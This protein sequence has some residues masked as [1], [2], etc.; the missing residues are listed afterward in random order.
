MSMWTA[1]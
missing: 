1:T